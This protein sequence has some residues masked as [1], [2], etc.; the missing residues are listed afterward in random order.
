M[1]AATSIFAVPPMPPVTRRRRRPLRALARAASWHR[2]KLAVLAAIASVLTGLSAAAPEGPAMTTVVKA[3]SQ[4]PGG[5]LLSASD[6]VLDQVV[7]SDVPEGVLTD[8]NELVGKTLAAPVAQNQMMTLLTTTAARTSVPSGHVIAPL[9]L[10]DLALTAL[11]RPG[12][13][14]DVVAA[15]PEG[16]EPATVVA[17]NVRVV[18]VPEAPND[19]ADP[20]PDG[21]L[22]LIEVDSRTAA[23]IAQAAASATLSVFWR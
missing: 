13:V 7:A 2:R 17:S 1:L 6:L 16:G 20:D 14:V 8:P 3:K 21:G 15:D 10:G 4:L 9:R 19:R 12:D 18:T 11:L 23:I 5:L 22:V